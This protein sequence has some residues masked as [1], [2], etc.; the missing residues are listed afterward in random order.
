MKLRWYAVE[1]NVDFTFT[2][3]TDDHCFKL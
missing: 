1:K 3:R 2:L